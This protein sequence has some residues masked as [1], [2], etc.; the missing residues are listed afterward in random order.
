MAEDTKKQSELNISIEEIQMRLGQ[1]DLEIILLQRTI[2]Q[3]QQQ[4]KMM[5]EELANRKET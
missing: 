4:N 5:K 2:S 3:L 1:K